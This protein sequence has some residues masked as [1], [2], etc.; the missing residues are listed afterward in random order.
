M[1]V[2]RKQS[3]PKFPKNKHCLPPDTDTYV[4]IWA[5][6]DSNSHL[7]FKNNDLYCHSQ[8]HI[9]E[10]NVSWVKEEIQ[11]SKGRYLKGAL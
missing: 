10:W 2:S 11:K 9:N 6:D 3:M 7:N 4:N 5:C 1:G 8:K